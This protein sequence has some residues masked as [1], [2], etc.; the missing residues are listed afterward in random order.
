MN[1]TNSKGDAGNNAFFGAT[2]FWAY[3]DRENTNDTIP[4]SLT[5]GKVAF[6]TRG[7]TEF[8]TLHSASRVNDGTYHHI[9]VTRNRTTGEKKIYVDGQLEASAT[10][11]TEPLNGNNYFYSIGGTSSQIDKSGTNFSSYI[12][13]LDDAQVYSGILSDSEVAMLYDN[14]GTIIPDTFVSE[15]SLGDALDASQF[16]WTTGGDAGWIVQTNTTH[17]GVDA[18][19]G[20]AIELNEISWLRTTVTG[21]G[22]VSFW[23]RNEDEF[24]SSQLL[25]LIDG[26][27]ESGFDCTDWRNDTFTIPPG[28]HVIEWQYSKYLLEAMSDLEA[29]GDGLNGAWV[30]EFVFSDQ[31]APV[32]TSTPTGITGFTGTNIQATVTLYGN[33]PP[34]LQWYKGFTELPGQTNATLTINNAQP[35]DTGGYFL[36]AS[37]YL[38][39]AFTPIFSIN[40]FDP[41]DLRPLTMAAPL[42]VGSQTF[43]P[44]SWLATNTGPGT[45]SNAFLDR[46][47]LTTNG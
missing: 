17:D 13:L 20:G 31:V 33:P 3:N 37:N 39:R 42:V 21:P 40:I 1:T 34:A 41:T 19:Q 44:I 38:G 28:V 35:S 8:E 12:G 43:V 2:I 46:V 22:R 11:T 23:W 18:A 47:Y 5:D 16:S 25:L 30:D 15:L 32:I 6:T 27:V 29:A 10:G 14:P 26:Q 4:I 45:I 36:I 7:Q 24:C 9:A